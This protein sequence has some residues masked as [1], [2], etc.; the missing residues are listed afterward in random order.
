MLNLHD[1]SS[2]ASELSK[3][4]VRLLIK[5]SISL[6]SVSLLRGYFLVLVPDAILFQLKYWFISM[7]TIHIYIFSKKLNMGRFERYNFGQVIKTKI[8]PV[9]SIKLA[10]D[11]L[12]V[13][14][15]NFR[16]ST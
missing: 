14:N 6:V 9:A 7:T 1:E 12:K 4:E 15:I 10:P 13:D 3:S 2:L 5:S 8:R 11:L 16:R